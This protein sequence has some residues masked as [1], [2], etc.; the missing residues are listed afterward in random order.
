M[1]SIPRWPVRLLGVALVTTA[2]S[3]C[4]S[5]FVS[6]PRPR[7][8][9]ATPHLPERLECS[10]T[11]PAVVDTGWAAANAF[12][13]YQASSQPPDTF[14]SGITVGPHIAIAA[15][16]ALSAAYGYSTAARC[17][18]ELERALPDSSSVWSPA[19]PLP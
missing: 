6:R 1:S 13:A 5:P 14:L 4:F 8:V 7:L 17:K 19:P 18:A 3:G 11:W 10:T 15:V 12:W 16:S 2:T 9:Y